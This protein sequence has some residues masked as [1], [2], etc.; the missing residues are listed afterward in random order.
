M[1]KQETRQEQAAGTTA[2]E[3]WGSPVPP[4]AIA[5]IHGLYTAWV[6]EDRDAVARLVPPGLDPAPDRVVSLFQGAQEGAYTSWGG[7]V[8]ITH[9]EVEVE[10]KDSLDGRLRGRWW[11]L[12]L[13]SDPFYLAG[14][15]L[16]GVPGATEGR[17]E[18]ALR[19]DRLTATTF[20]GETPIIRTTAE[21]GAEPVAPFGV[22]MRYLVPGEG[23]PS[24]LVPVAAPAYDVKVLDIEFLD[25]SHPSY[26]FRPMKPLEIAWSLY[27]PRIAYAFS[28]PTPVP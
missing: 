25:P 13:N 3:L 6:P 23:F 10:G 15:K 1:T 21:V 18:I 11:V 20:A 8:T 16:I 2:P 27:S 28:A 12:Y 17:T 22:Q 7:L 4:H 14:A 24:V 19:G 26:A 5:E 9:A